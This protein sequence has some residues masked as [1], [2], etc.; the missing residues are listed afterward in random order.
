MN[1]I[2][3]ITTISTT[4]NKFSCSRTVGY[5]KDLNKAKEIVENNCYDL[6]ETFYG[7][8]VIEEVPEGIYPLYENQVWYKWNLKE[9]KYEECERP[10]FAMNCGYCEGIG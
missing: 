8:A 6:F 10:E 7:Y 2:F 3:L 9:N 5:F 1:N 4:N